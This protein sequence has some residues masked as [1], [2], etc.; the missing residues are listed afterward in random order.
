MIKRSTTFFNALSESK[1]SVKIFLFKHGAFYQRF[2]INTGDSILASEG[3]VQ[4]SFS[5][6]KT[7]CRFEQQTVLNERFYFVSAVLNQI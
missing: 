4:N 5:F 1:Q 3:L 7:L 6:T 2:N